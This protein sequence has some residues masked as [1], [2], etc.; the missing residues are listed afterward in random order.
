MSCFFF[1][2]R[3]CVCVARAGEFGF[4]DGRRFNVGNYQVGVFQ[5]LLAFFN[6]FLALRFVCRR[7]QIVSSVIG[8]ENSAKHAGNRY[9]WSCFVMKFDDVADRRTRQFRTRTWKTNFG[10]LLKLVTLQS[11]D[12][13]PSC[14]D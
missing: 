1:G 12:C 11:L 10:A 6:I 3:D 14:V 7:V 2:L 9:A 13:F 5:S 4:G 8:S